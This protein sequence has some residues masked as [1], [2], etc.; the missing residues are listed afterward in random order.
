MRIDDLFEELA[1][2]KKLFKEVYLRLM[3]EEW[4]EIVG[5]KISKHVLP[6]KV[7]SNVLYV[8]YDDP[9]FANEF[10]MRSEEILKI[11]NKKLK[12]IVQ[13]EDIKLMRRGG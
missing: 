6:K 1:R 8:S 10:R 4:K 3:L 12:G 2:R 11:L 5:E 9:L 13:I 7:E